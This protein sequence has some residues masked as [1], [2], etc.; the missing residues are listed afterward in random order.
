MLSTAVRVDA[1]D[2]LRR[3]SELE[4][5]SDSLSPILKGS[6][7][8]RKLMQDEAGFVIT[9]ELV[10]V[11][12][13]AVLGMVVGL[14]AV[15]DAIT[16]EMNDLSHAFGAV[17]QTYNVVGIR[18]EKLTGKPHASAAGFGFND[19]SDDCDCKPIRYHDV[20]GKDDPSNGAPNENNNQ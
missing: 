6:P 15:R 1:A 18:K 13:I 16:N 5:L 9:A 10:L 17:N 11:L 12:T 7:I 8:M 2:S 3:R 4:R 14:T 20:C 19:A